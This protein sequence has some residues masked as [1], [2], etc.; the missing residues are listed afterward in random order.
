MLYIDGALV[1]S[2][3]TNSGT[4]RPSDVLVLGASLAGD[5]ALNG[6]LDDV[7]IWRG[8]RYVEAFTPTRCENVS[9]A[10]GLMGEWLFEEGSGVSPADTS[11]N[12]NDGALMGTVT[13]EATP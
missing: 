13:F 12:D 9:W 8:A 2:S 7:R 6:S 1:A 3:N 11:G 5:E 4:V 10:P